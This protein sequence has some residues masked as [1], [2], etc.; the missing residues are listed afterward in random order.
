MILL[1]LPYYGT[2]AIRL[3]GVGS[4]RLHS[5]KTRST[6]LDVSP[7]NVI[8]HE[9]S[10][11]FITLIDWKTSGSYPSYILDAEAVSEL[12]KLFHALHLFASPALDPVSRRELR[13][14]GWAKVR[15][16]KGEL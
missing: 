10:R 9:R 16:L 4:T 7:G 2:L 5:E 13:E 12:E 15:E 8:L 6:H 11:C 3:I 14:K 1:E